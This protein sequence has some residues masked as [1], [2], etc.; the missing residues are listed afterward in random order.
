[1]LY[2]TFKINRSEF[3]MKTKTKY[4]M[5]T[6]SRA[7]LM[8]ADIVIELDFRALISTNSPYMASRRRHC[9]LYITLDRVDNVEQTRA[10]DPNHVPPCRI[11][12]MPTQ[13][14]FS[15]GSNQLNDTVPAMATQ[16]QCNSQFEYVRQ[17]Q[18]PPMPLAFQNRPANFF[19]YATTVDGGDSLPYNNAVEQNDYHDIEIDI[20][21]PDMSQHCEYGRNIAEEESA[22]K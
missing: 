12:T 9:P 5:C 4:L 15:N 8:A 7:G 10:E 11:P 21:G 16:S 20:C 6:Q 14:M 2:E 13:F 18:V 1:M 22:P 19:D 17:S 3:I